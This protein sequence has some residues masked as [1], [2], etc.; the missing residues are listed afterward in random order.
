MHDTTSR[1][2]HSAKVLSFLLVCPVCKTEKLIHSLDYEPRFEPNGQPE[3]AGAT[4][5][6]LRTEQPGQPTR[7]AA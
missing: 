4:V 5:H 2:D 6:Q 3:A 7:R 1:Y